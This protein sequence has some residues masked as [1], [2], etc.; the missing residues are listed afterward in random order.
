MASH[1]QVVCGLVELALELLA[2]GDLGLEGGA[3]PSFE[4]L[5]EC[6]DA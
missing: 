4:A 3:R 2:E 6:L 5:L 1:A